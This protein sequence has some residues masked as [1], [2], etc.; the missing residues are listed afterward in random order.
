[1]EK[2]QQKKQWKILVVSNIDDNFGDNLIKICF[3]SLL[4][5]V[6]ENLKMDTSCITIRD[7]SIKAPDETLI[8]DSDIIAFAGGGLFG[9]SYLNFFDALDR[10]TV[11][12]EEHHIP[13]FFSS[14]GVNNMDGNSENEHKLHA[15]LRRKCIKAISVR[16]NLHL[17]RSFAGNCDYEI[18][19]VC[20]PAVW[21]RYIYHS[22]LQD[23]PKNDSELVGINVARGGLFNDNGKQWKLG[24]EITFLNELKKELEDRGIDYRF[25]TNGSFLDDNA[26]HYYAD[27]CNISEEKL[28]YPNTTRELVQTV[29]RFDCVATIRMHSSI[30]SYALGIP[31]VNL[32][33]NDKIPYFYKNIG[34]PERAMELEHWHGKEVFACLQA[35][36]N[37]NN[38][39]LDEEYLMS[40][41]RYLY[42]VMNQLCGIEADEAAVYDIETVKAVLCDSAVPLQE[43]STD[44][45]LKLRKSEKHYLSRFKDMKTKDAELSELKKELRRKTKEAE[46]K[47]KE[48]QRLRN[49]LNKL[50][51]LPSVFLIRAAFYAYKKLRKFAK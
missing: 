47:T 4:N 21:S 6:F 11:L 29:A 14:I 42:R 30:I 24:D 39:Q 37:D 20:D 32:N 17:F 8:L 51:F 18:C 7:M 19:R 38:Y 40:L 43:D 28:I 27:Q 12:A 33:W 13:V 25:Y 15:I 31:S 16:E 3:E 46:K 22:Y 26:L 36:R 49:Y 50:S 23:I 35:I 5:V 10:I 48:S 45:A 1:M 9:L 34:H 41:Y 44:Y 2:T